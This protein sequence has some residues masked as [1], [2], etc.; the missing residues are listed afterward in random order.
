MLLIL[1]LLSDDSQLLGSLAWDIG[2][3]TSKQFARM[4]AGLQFGGDVL[5]FLGF[6]AILV[7]NGIIAKD[8]GSSPW[9]RVDAIMLMA[10]NS[11]PW[12]ICA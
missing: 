8:L 9:V 3:L 12:V 7:T 1:G 4:H 11:F 2:Q 10:Y 5:A 6:V